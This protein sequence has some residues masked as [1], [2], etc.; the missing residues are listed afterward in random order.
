VVVDPD[1]ARRTAATA[2]GADATIDPAGSDWHEQALAL[3][4]GDGYDHVIEAS[5]RPEG[6][7]DALELTARAAR[8]LVYGV[9]RPGEVT[10]VQPQQVYAKELTILGAALNPFTHARAVELLGE[11]PLQV[12]DPGRYP[13]DAF[14]AAFDAQRRRAHLKVVLTP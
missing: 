12:L 14:E 6:L 10:P 3:T 11:L 7:A 13:L 1:A 9:A 5:G 2:L 4:N 8:I